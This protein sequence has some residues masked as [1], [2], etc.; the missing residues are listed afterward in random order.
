MGRSLMPV[1]RRGSR[2]GHL[3]RLVLTAWPL[4]AVPCSWA[5][6]D[7]AT[8]ALRLNVSFYARQSLS[9]FSPATDS[10]FA[11][12]GSG[13]RW[14]HETE[15]RS[16]AEVG[17]GRRLKIELHNETFYQGGRGRRWLGGFGERL[18]LPP[19]LDTDRLMEDR[20]RV[21]DLTWT[22]DRDPARLLVNRVDRLSAS[23]FLGPTTLEVGRQVITWGNGF[24]FNP[25][26]LF[27]PFAPVETERDYKRGEDGLLWQIDG[28]RR[29]GDLEV[30][31]VF[32]RDEAGGGVSWRE[33]SVAA[34]HHRLISNGSWEM[35]SLAAKHYGDVVLGAGVMGRLGDVVCRSEWTYTVL[36]PRGGAWTGVV[37]M[38]I[39]WIW[40]GL[41]S[42]A[43]IEYYF[44]GFGEGPGSG[45]Q[46]SRGQ[47]LRA[48][49]ARGDAFV[50]RRH[51][52]DGRLEV[53]VHPLVRV[54]LNTVANLPHASGMLQ[55]AAVWDVTNRLQFRITGT[56]L[57]G[58]R[59]TE[60][61]GAQDATSGLRDR[62]PNR[63]DARL[64][65]SF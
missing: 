17:W 19:S 14:G 51:Y 47:A 8:E 3:A 44:S 33:A 31:S 22:L 35:T 13:P 60:F 7:A 55:P 49:L 37:N 11:S 48:R 6:E 27:G 39:A 4:V 50:R 42:H 57:W 40:G 43:G 41:N 28:G 18:D 34:K 36:R 9:R 12:L 65:V 46:T 20:R 15:V 24:L 23:L 45:P 32:R 52:L 58:G 1:H 26:D 29:Y 56:W 2:L 61:G 64:T 63:V 62:M 25:F 21:F 59:D 53:E 54:S 16:M 10:V 30:V 5:E 38:D